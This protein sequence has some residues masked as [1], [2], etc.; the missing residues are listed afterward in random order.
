M[1][2]HTDIHKEVSEKEESI[3]ISVFFTKP[4]TELH[5]FVPSEYLLN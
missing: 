3:L 5:M 4:N 2:K 1:V